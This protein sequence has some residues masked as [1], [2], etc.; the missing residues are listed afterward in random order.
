MS[1]ST[2]LR[3]HVESLFS[4]VGVI[5]AQYVL[6][7]TVWGE[8]L[9]LDGNMTM[10]TVDRFMNGLA[11]T[12]GIQMRKLADKDTSLAARTGG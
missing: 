7:P 4:N 10:E 2:A 9:Y 5:T 12:T 1:T 6:L 8:R 11:T 3:A